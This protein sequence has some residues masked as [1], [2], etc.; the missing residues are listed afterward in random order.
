MTQISVRFT[1]IKPITLECHS[2]LTAM[3][4]VARIGHMYVVNND[5]T[6]RKETQQKSGKKHD[7]TLHSSLLL[8]P[9]FAF[10][11]FVLASDGIEST[12]L[13]VTNAACLL[14]LHYI[15]FRLIRHVAKAVITPDTGVLES[16]FTFVLCV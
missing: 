6:M 2:A 16:L 11:C 4:S 12:H 5:R 15:S 3:T 14:D 10:C 8:V 9:Y 7:Q 1:L 13:C